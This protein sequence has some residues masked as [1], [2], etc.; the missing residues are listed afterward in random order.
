VL[1]RQG[2]TT[3]YRYLTSYPLKGVNADPAWGENL[4][5]GDVPEGNWVLQAWHQG[6]VVSGDV[7]VREG[8]TSWVSLRLPW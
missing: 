8:Q 2:S 5:T 3:P 1:Y 4:C 7:V 6:A